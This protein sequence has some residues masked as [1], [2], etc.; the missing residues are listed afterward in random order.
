[1]VF[2]VPSLTSLSTNNSLHIPK[3][4][5]TNQLSETE[6]FPGLPLVSGTLEDEMIAIDAHNVTLGLPSII[7]NPP[8]PD[9]T[10]YVVHDGQIQGVWIHKKTTGHK[11]QE[12]LNA[13]RYKFGTLVTDDDKSDS[14]AED[15]G[16]DHWQLHPAFK[17]PN[18]GVSP[19]YE[20]LGMWFIATFPKSK[21][22]R[23]VVPANL[24][25]E[26]RAL[27]VVAFGNYITA[28]ERLRGFCSASEAA[29][30]LVENCLKGNNEPAKAVR[31]VRPVPGQGRK[32]GREIKFFEVRELVE[33][34]ERMR[35]CDTVEWKVSELWEIWMVWMN[36]IDR[37]IRNL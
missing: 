1:M 29:A 18:G 7:P 34:L 33:W 27:L 14:D 35:K 5:P 23:F 8:G 22:P 11:L 28:D 3:M 9:E 13:I 15:T 31:V 37:F 6:N 10:Q 4:S 16:Q 25:H 36:V 19:L 20:E 26:L 21:T 12:I 17:G 2:Y 32:K 30:Y 24:R